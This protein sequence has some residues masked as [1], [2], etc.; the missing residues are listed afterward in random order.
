M[1]NQSNIVGTCFTGKG[2][3]LVIL[4]NDGVIFAWTLEGLLAQGVYDAE[5]RKLACSPSSPT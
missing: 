1:S 5:G 4:Y 3:F 2:A